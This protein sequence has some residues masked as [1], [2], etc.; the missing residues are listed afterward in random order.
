MFRWSWILLFISLCPHCLGAEDGGCAER[1]VI[2]SA[3][4]SNGKAIPFTL[5][6]ADI[7]GKINGKPVQILG[8]TKPTNAERV[9]IVLDA[10]GSMSSVWQRALEF[11]V[12]IVKESPS[13]TEFA[14]VI[15]ADN[16]L[17]TVEFGKTGPE[18][19]TEIKSFKNV[20]PYGHT[21]LRDAIWEAVSMFQPNQDGDTIVVI[22]DGEDNQSKVSKRRL[23]EAMWSRR[24]RVMFAQIVDHVV[25]PGEVELN[26]A[27]TTWLSESS[28]GFLSRIENPNMLPDVAQEIVFEIEN[29][30]AVRI[31][32]PTPLEKET[33]LHLE[34]IDPSGRKRKNIELRFPEKLP[35]CASLA[36]RR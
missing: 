31:T 16:E 15:F 33:P 6:S 34:A 24:I 9:V 3:S 25:P 10:S 5:Q 28:G 19:I 26:D 22:S 29:Y 8:V 12:E 30:L 4:D 17:R 18:F 7:Q 21:A 36:S 1:T 32:L 23:Q 35:P 14:L 11:A 2:V 27:D 20:K 13:S